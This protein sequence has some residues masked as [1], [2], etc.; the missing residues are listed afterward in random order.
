MFIQKIAKPKD[1]L[2]VNSEEDIPEF[3][4]DTIKIEGDKIICLAAE[5]YNESPLGSVIG[6]DKKAPTQTGKGAWPLGENSFVEK[7][8]VFYP[9]PEIRTAERIKPPYSLETKWGIQN[10][11]IG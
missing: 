11:E 10:L 6:F 7:D 8:G 4:K 9:A 5:G 3:L 2:R 1:A